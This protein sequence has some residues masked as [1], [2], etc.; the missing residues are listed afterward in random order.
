MKTV[1]IGYYGFGNAGDD[2]LC[3]QAISLIKDADPGAEIF[4]LTA[5]PLNLNDE[6]VFELERN[7]YL[8]LIK[9]IYSCDQVVLG[10]GSLFQNLSS[11]LSLYYYCFLCLTAHFFGKPLLALGIG[12]GPIKGWLNILLCRYV[13]KLFKSVSFR[14]SM[15]YLDF[16]SGLKQA[17][18]ASDLVFYN[19]DQIKSAYSPSAP[20]GISVNARQLRDKD[21]EEIRAL[22]TVDYEWVAIAAQ[23]HIDDRF[24]N[25]LKCKGEYLSDL[26]N[27][28]YDFSIQYSC[29][30]SSRFHTCVWAALAGVPFI[31]IG[32]DPKCISF[33]TQL[34]QEHRYEWS[35][36]LTDVIG[37][38]KAKDEWY[39][40]RLKAGVIEFSKQSD[41]LY[42]SLK[43]FV[44]VLGYEVTTL[45][46]NLVLRYLENQVSVSELFRVITLNPEMVMWAKKD[47]KMH[48]WITSADLIVA[49]GQGIRLASKLENSEAVPIIPGI[50]LV[51]ALCLTAKTIALIGA[52]EQSVQAC[53]QQLEQRNEQLKVVVCS[54]GFFD[55]TREIEIIN[56]LKKEQPQ[57]IFV[58]MGFPKQEYFIQTCKE[59]EIGGMIVGVGGS[60]DVISGQ[61]PRAPKWV[62][63][64]KGEWLYRGVTEPARFKKWGYMPSFLVRLGRALI[65][66]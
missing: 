10:G 57:Y 60:F 23:Q 4:V 5:S 16:S 51:E 63:R 59:N 52:S 36:D 2:F 14:D 44:S 53:R 54:N 42:L 32:Y 38:V 25:W 19:A 48:K 17:Y 29:V 6:C 66:N 47:K 64:L 40:Q 37:N 46:F 12:M 56:Q 61:L 11:S 21:V 35:S 30:V 39:R 58:G 45:P 22:L 18:L 50:D 27:G 13:L 7:A 55:K 41:N 15:S 65:S 43:P 28:E 31:S 9:T 24:F 49:D 26:L 20:V 3:K 8:K 33:S 34:G 62:R 1:L